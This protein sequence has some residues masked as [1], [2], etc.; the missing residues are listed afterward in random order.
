MDVRYSRLIVALLAAV[1]LLLLGSPAGGAQAATPQVSQAGK[2]HHAVCP[3]PAKNGTARCNADVRDDAEALN[4]VPMPAGSG[5]ASPNVLGNGGAYDPS[6]LQSAYQTPSVSGGSG[7][8]VAIVDAYDDPNAASDLAYY[9]SFFGLSPCGTSNGCFRKVDQTGGTSYPA[10][11]SGWAQEIS[12][13][14][15]MV[16]AICPNCNI[17]LVEATSNSF[18]D[19]ATAVNEAAALGA[20]AISNSYGGTEWSG[21]T[22]SEGSYHH[23]GIAVTVSSGD[24]GYGVQ[25][26]A[27]SQYVTAVGGTTLNQLTNTGTRSATETV[28]SGAG[29][30]CSAYISKPSWQKD[31]G[32]S[33]RTVADTSAVADPNTGVWVYDT[34]PAGGWYVF[35]GTSVASPIVAAV[36]A[37]AGNGPSTSALNS[38]PY[39]H[40]SSLN[41]I[42]S[43]SNGTCSPAYL[44]T[45]EVGYDGPTGLGTPNGTSAFTNGP[46]TPPA[47]ATN[48][49]V[50]ASPTSV[51]ANG[52]AAS[53]ITVT[54]K[55]ASNN[56]VSGKTVT[57]GQG[58]GHSTISPSSGT[59]DSS[60]VVKFSVTDTTAESVTYTATDSTDSVTVSQTATVNFT[61]A[62]DF[63][64]SAS[65]MSLSIRRNSGGT[66]VVTVK[67]TSGLDSS[68]SLSVSGLPS[69]TTASF[70]PQSVTSSTSGTQSTLNIQTGGSRGTFTLTITGTGGG[71]T[72]STTLT[73]KITR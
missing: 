10:G 30:G 12:L 11:N 55:D 54:L 64:L 31:S 49:A 9:R 63:S 32:C 68:V 43:G 33:R 71:R 18:A 50:S 8:T 51:L 5:G 57:L 36:F 60:G 16:S 70:N 26:P 42:T 21:E 2:S 24:N 20:N 72:H 15:E 4:S 28:W 13:D 44:C 46:S 40:S 25:F 59:S 53:A 62:P 22:A 65:P 52:S 29:S 14:L 56:P 35:G 41:D 47:S 45:G 48:S 17:L 73:L 66:D 58:T 69:G 27:A 23:P 37:L 7:Q 38:D 61:A 34:Y 3:G 19:L 39:N 1:S 67:T 6:Y